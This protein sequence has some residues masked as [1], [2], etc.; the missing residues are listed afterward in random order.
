MAIFFSP[1]RLAFFDEAIHGPR[2]LHLV[3]EKAL[4]K[5]I[6]KADSDEAR[7]AILVEPP[8]IVERHPETM[9]PGD[10]VEISVER[11]AELMQALSAGKVLEADGEEPVVAEPPVN[12]DEQLEGFRRQRD[13][14]LASTDWT[15]LPD[16]LTTAKRKLWAEHRKALR[17]LP[18]MVEK[19]LAAGKDPP[20]FPN[21]PK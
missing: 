9:I 21:P 8:V 16:A 12:I 4:Q 1:S 10:A 20:P 13:Q 18:T 7:E 15:Q 19:A 11:H 14:A 6:E 5:A 17:D 2:Y 3:D